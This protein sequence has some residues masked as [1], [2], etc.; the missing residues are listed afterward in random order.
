M[1]YLP[2]STDQSA[3]AEVWTREPV[4]IAEHGPHCDH[5]QSTEFSFQDKRSND[6]DVYNGTCCTQ[7]GRILTIAKRE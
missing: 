3:Y 2:R 4:T 5:P 7:C 6:L 1:K